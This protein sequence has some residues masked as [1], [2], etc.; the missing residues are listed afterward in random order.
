MTEEMVVVVMMVV[1]VTRKV[2][3]ERCTNNGTGL[4]RCDARRIGEVV[5]LMVLLLHCTGS[6]RRQKVALLATNRQKQ[7]RRRRRRQSGELVIGGGNECSHLDTSWE[8][9]SRC[10]SRVLQ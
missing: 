9:H 5:A 1:A 10:L 7:Q 3:Q 4:L 2:T 8:L 6:V